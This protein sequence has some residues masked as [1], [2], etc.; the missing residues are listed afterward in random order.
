MKYDLEFVVWSQN[1]ETVSAV[2]AQATMH[3]A[4]IPESWGL[5]L[6][7]WELCQHRQFGKRN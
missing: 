2:F 7:S 1:R 3:K 4:Y 5:G 6:M